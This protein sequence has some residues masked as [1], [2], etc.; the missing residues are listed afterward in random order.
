MFYI[1]VKSIFMPKLKWELL[2]MSLIIFL[3]LNF[4]VFLQIISNRIK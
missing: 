1:R 4:F 2:D 3:M